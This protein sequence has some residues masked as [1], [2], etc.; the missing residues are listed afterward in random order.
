VVGIA[1][2]NR[3]AVIVR[4]REH[5]LDTVRLVFKS[6]TSFYL[7]LV[8]FPVYLGLH[9]STTGSRARAEGPAAAFFRPG[10]SQQSPSAFPPLLDL[11]HLQL[12]LQPLVNVERR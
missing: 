10:R 6:L 1:D 8:S 7:A 5:S 9:R 12:F 2:I 11:E 4:E 3:T